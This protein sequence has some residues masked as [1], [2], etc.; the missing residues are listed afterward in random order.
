MST[1]TLIKTTK[2]CINSKKWEE[3][4][5]TARKVLSFEPQ[6]HEA[7][8]L[9]SIHWDLS[10]SLFRLFYQ[11]YALFH[12]KSFEESEESFKN[13]LSLGQTNAKQ[14][15]PWQ[16]LLMVYEAQINVPE[17]IK[18]ATQLSELFKDG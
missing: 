1:K 13:V 9:P 5:S 17:Y 2:A 18:T 4:V 6:N 11:G 3:A 14:L 10:N 7:Y 15:A 12:L 16:G 8:A